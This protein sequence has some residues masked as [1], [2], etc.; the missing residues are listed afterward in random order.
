MNGI[1]FNVMKDNTFRHALKSCARPEFVV[2][3]YNK[4]REA[5]LD[6]LKLTVFECVKKNILDFIPSLHLYICI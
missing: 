1:P 5:Y 2:L 6:K 3:E 4:M